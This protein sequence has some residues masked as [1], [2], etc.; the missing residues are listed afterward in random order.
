MAKASASRTAQTVAEEYEEC[1]FHRFRASD[2][3]RHDREPGFMLDFFRAFNR[4]TLTRSIKF[5]VA[6]VGQRD[7]DEYADRLTFEINTAQNRIHPATLPI[8]NVRR[9]ESELRRWRY[10][11]QSQYQQSRERVNKKL[12]EASQMRVQLQ[13]EGVVDHKIRAGTQETMPHGWRPGERNTGCFRLY[14]YPSLSGSGN[15]SVRELEEGEY[16]VDENLESHTGKKTRYGRQQREFLV[17]WKGVTKTRAVFRKSTG[18]F[19]FIMGGTDL[20]RWTAIP[21]GGLGLL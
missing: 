17:R 16:E 6:E 4:M 18:K 10:R 11:I 21:L 15:S 9:Q 7:W 13:N 14:T 3:I 12:R 2:A 8:V 20:L 19:M 1:V 5:Y